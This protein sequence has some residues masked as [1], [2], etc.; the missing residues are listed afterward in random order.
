M[1]EAL[2]RT[3]MRKKLIKVRSALI[4]LEQ[5]P[6]SSKSISSFRK[7]LSLYNPISFKK[8]VLNSLLNLKCLTHL[9]HR[10][11]K[12][13]FIDLKLSKSKSK[14]KKKCLLPLPKF[15]KKSPK[16]KWEKSS[17]KPPQNLLKFK[18]PTSASKSWSKFTTSSEA[19]KT[20][21]PKSQSIH[22]H[23]QPSNKK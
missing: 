21:Q 14:A 7:L 16:S 9:K 4:G 19:Q 20:N 11:S 22:N 6:P 17:T 3:R 23:P 2:S 5:W 15:S 13:A 8:F 1:E 10:P 12:M 18:T